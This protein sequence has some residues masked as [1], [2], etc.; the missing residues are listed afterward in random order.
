MTLKFVLITM[1]IFD[2]TIHYESQWQ[3][4]NIKIYCEGS[5]V[6]LSHGDYL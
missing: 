1:V 5:L 3:I 4:Y 2:I 6:S